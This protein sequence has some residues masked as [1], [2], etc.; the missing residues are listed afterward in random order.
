M[1]EIETKQLCWI[2]NKVCNYIIFVILLD[3]KAMFMFRIVN[4]LFDHG[5]QFTQM[6][7]SLFV[8]IV[9]IH[10]WTTSNLNYKSTILLTF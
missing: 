3:Q 2:A 5:P 1:K 10:N 9:Y 6:L 7:K 4:H 8:V